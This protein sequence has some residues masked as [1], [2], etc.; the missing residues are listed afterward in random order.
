MRP[1]TI[2]TGIVLGSAFSIAFGLAVVKFIFWVIGDTSPQVFAESGSLWLSIGLFSLL[3][4]FSALS[5]V[6]LLRNHPWWPLGQ[7][8]LWL[9]IALIG[10][11]YWP[12]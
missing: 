12:V 9:N 8:L 11:T 1:L 2:I 5:F 6:A 4:A 3:T 7:V 10:R